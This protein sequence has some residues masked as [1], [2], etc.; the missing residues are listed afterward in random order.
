M[1]H[2]IGILTAS[3]KPGRLGGNRANFARVCREA[4]RSGVD[5]AVFNIDP[6]GTV[7]SYGW[8]SGERAFRLVRRPLPPVLYNRIPLRSWEQRPDTVRRFGE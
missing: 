4:K 2:E 5:C 6:H 1:A 8:E 7:T 3:G